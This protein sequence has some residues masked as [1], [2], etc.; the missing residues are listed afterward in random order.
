MGVQRLEQK[1]LLAPAGAAALGPPEVEG[2]PAPGLVR[3]ME[4]EGRIEGLQSVRRSLAQGSGLHQQVRVGELSPAQTEPPA[5]GQ[6]R[7]LRL[8]RGQVQRREYM[9][10]A[11]DCTEARE[12]AGR[13]TEEGPGP[14][15][16]KPQS[17]AADSSAPEK[18]TETR[19]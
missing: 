16:S 13:S 12:T 3:R 14:R 2:R 7:V 8:A 17:A 10:V 15:R 5:P 6:G 19:V 1:Q 9:T 11:G 4:Q 18:I